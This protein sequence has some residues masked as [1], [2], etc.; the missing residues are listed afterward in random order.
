ML[1]SDTRS[2]QAG[3]PPHLKAR[4]SFLIVVEN[5]MADRFRTSVDV[6]EVGFDTVER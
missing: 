4:P 1:S 3:D 5:R 2:L 6:V